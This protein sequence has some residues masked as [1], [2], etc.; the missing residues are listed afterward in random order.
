M[1][2]Y[3]IIYKGG[4]ILQKII[5][6]SNNKNALNLLEIPDYNV[7]V[8]CKDNKYTL[9]NASGQELFTTVADDIYDNIRRREE[10][11]YLCK[12]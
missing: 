10:L 6:A 3:V 8:A 1:W 2:Y 11:L 7:F 5:I 12:W 4:F 9:V